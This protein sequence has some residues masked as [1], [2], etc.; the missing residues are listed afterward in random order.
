MCQQKQGSKSESWSNDVQADQSL[1]MKK[2]PISS[3][4]T[5]KYR[6]GTTIGYMHVDLC[7]RKRNHESSVCE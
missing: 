5:E 7:A 6:T 4:D 1:V 3:D 2:D